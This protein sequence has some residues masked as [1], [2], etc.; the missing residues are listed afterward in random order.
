[1]TNAEHGAEIDVE[2]VIS[3][4]NKCEDLL[5]YYISEALKKHGSRSDLNSYVTRLDTILGYKIS[6]CPH[7]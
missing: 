2:H 4:S 3:N 7:K 6:S 1:M 5:G